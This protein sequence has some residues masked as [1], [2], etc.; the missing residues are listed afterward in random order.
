[1][2]PLAPSLSFSFMNEFKFQEHF[3]SR[4]PAFVHVTLVGV[5]DA[6]NS[7][8]YVGLVSNIAV[9]GPFAYAFP[10]DTLQ[11]LVCSTHLAPR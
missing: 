10:H 1:M 2:N 9:Q 7:E 6:S 3:A 5:Q 8:L 4:E 11:D